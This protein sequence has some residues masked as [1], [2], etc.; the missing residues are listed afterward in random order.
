MTSGEQTPVCI[1]GVTGLGWF[2]QDIRDNIAAAMGGKHSPAVRPSGEQRSAERTVQNASPA[3]YGEKSN[4]S[5]PYR[6]RYDEFAQ[7]YGVYGGER[8][9][10]SEETAPQPSEPVTAQTVLRELART[11]RRTDRLL[12]TD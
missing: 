4:P 3:E 12:V 5:L 2:E 1:R 9:T 7:R 8:M 11:L 10:Q 6:G